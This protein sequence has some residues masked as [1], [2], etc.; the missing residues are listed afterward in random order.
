M[1]DDRLLRECEYGETIAGIE[2]QSSNSFFTV[3][4]LL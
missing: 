3:I 4:L 2:L 1:T